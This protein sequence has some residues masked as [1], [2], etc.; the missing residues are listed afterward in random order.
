[1]PPP[2]PVTLAS[3]AQTTVVVVE[4]VITAVTTPT[5]AKALAVDTPEASNQSPVHQI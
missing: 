5:S 4:A 1:M 3:P 2:V